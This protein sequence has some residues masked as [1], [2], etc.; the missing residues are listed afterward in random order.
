MWRR[1]RDK[2]AIQRMSDDI[3]PKIKH[4]KA[5]SG[6]EMDEDDEEE[7]MTVIKTAEEL[8]ERRGEW[9]EKE[10]EIRQRGGPGLLSC[11]FCRFVFASYN[12]W[13][14]HKCK[15]GVIAA[16]SSIKYRV[17]SSEEEIEFKDA[18]RFASPR[19]KLRVCVVAKICVPGVFPLLF[20]N[21]GRWT[22]P[23]LGWMGEEVGCAF[24][25]FA[26]LSSAEKEGLVLLPESM[27]VTM[28]DGGLLYLPPSL[29][30]P[31]R[32]ERDDTA[33]KETGD[34]SDGVWS[35]TESSDSSEDTDDYQE[36]GGGS[37]G[38]GGMGGVGGSDGQ[39]SGGGGS[40]EEG[41]AG[42]GGGGTGGGGRDTGGGGSR[43]GESGGGP[44]GR[45]GSGG[46]PSGGGGSGGGSSGGGGSGGGS[47]G[48]GGSGGGGSNGGGSGAGGDGDRASRGGGS[49]PNGGGGGDGRGGARPSRRQLQ[50]MSPFLNW[51][52]FTAEEFYEV[53]S[54]LL[55]SSF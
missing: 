43:G 29:L 10:E 27:S 40:S 42:T 30:R 2:E 38:G 1:Q 16:E 26:T 32:E 20:L 3:L 50:L 45:G 11:S 12:G 19:E 13:K 51:H 22:K 31:G 49:D 28:R 15:L 48:G 24:Q 44:S 35:D 9:E 21:K 54:L 4:E 41:G 7:A 46:G 55:K 14:G 33:V 47:S 37:S 34:S 5:K 52:F 17:L 18:M 36:S 25:S 8:K 6:V 23:T 39:V 53:T